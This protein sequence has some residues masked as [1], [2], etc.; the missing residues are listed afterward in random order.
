MSRCNCS[1][2]REFRITGE[3]SEHPR[4]SDMVG[5]GSKAVRVRCSHC[6]G[7]IGR[8][9]SDVLT[10][11]LQIPESEIKPARCLAEQEQRTLTVDLI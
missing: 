3:V 11:L 8:I 2:P 10:E 7:K 9:G 6:G 5:S 1:T 4:P